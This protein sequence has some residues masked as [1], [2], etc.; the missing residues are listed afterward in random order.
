MKSAPSKKTVS[1]PSSGAP[2]AFF[3][4]SLFGLLAVG[5][6]FLLSNQQFNMMTA[7]LIVF[8]G[9][10]LLYRKNRVQLTWKAAI[11]ALAQ[12]A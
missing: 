12:K 6:G 8:A 10:L 9:T 4:L 3:H 7:S 5:F 11:A 2:E 1:N